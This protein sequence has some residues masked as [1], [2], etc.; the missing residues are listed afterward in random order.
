MNGQAFCFLDIEDFFLIFPKKSDQMKVKAI[1][2]GFA[3]KQVSIA[4][5]QVKIENAFYALNDY[6]YLQGEMFSDFYNI[7]S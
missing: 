4:E 7:R 2:N 5:A 6:I 1:I 3:L